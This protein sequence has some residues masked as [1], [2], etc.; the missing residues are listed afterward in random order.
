MKTLS[1]NHFRIDW[2]ECS[3]INRACAQ[4]HI[5]EYINN[6]IP[7][8]NKFLVFWPTHYVN[9]YL[10]INIKVNT[11]HV[12]LDIWDHIY[13]VFHHRI[14]DAGLGIH[15]KNAMNYMRNY[16]PKLYTCI[17]DILNNHD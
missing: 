5:I 9:K 4:S 8:N 14:D 7:I 13:I 17:Q 6:S 11:T 15:N 16:M 2:G 3:T 1:C 12:Y 10:P